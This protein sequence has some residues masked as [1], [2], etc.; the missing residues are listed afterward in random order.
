MSML[1]LINLG[2]VT[3]AIGYMGFSDL[4][5]GV[6]YESRYSAS[7]TGRLPSNLNTHACT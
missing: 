1:D 2:H 5:S 7:K 4:S 6:Y 3:F